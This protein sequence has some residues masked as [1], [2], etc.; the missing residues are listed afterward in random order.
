MADVTLSDGR[1]ITF[2]LLKISQKEYRALFSNAQPDT[3]GDEIVGR[4][5]GMS[6]E[7]VGDLPQPD[8]RRLVRAFFKRAS[9]PLDDSKN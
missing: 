5:C 1:E 7:E 6:A 9:E 3:E 4:C 8:Y 2:D